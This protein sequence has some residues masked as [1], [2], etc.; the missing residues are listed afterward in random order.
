MVEGVEVCEWAEFCS[1]VLAG[2]AEG[3]TETERMG[4]ERGMVE[5]VEDEE[6]GPREAG[7]TPVSASF[8]PTGGERERPT[9]C[10]RETQE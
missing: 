10:A 4:G 6:E 9:A 7:A 1:G 3:V 5:E 8:M 2:E